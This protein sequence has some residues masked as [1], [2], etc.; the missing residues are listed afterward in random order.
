MFGEGLEINRME[1]TVTE[2]S[3]TY[4]S[5]AVNQNNNA[6]SIE[7]KCGPTDWGKIVPIPPTVNM[8][9]GSHQSPIDIRMDQVKVVKQESPKSET[10]TDKMEFW[11]SFGVIDGGCRDWTQFADDHT[12]EVNFSETA[13]RPSCKNLNVE[14]SGGKK[15]WNLKQLHFHSPSEHALESTEMAAEVHMVHKSDSGDIMVI[16]VLL[17]L[18]PTAD[19]DD[20]EPLKSTTTENDRKG[21]SDNAFLANFWE[22]AAE[23]AKY[24]GIGVEND[25]KLAMAVHDEWEVRASS[26]PINPYDLITVNPATGEAPFFSYMGSLS[27][28]P[29]TENVRWLV[30]LQPAEISKRDLYLLRKAP[31]LFSGGTLLDPITNNN[32]RPVQPLNGRIVH[33][34]PATGGG[35]TGTTPHQIKEPALL[36]S[37]G[38]DKATAL[39]FLPVLL[40]AALAL[41]L[42]IRWFLSPPPTRPKGLM[43]MVNVADA[44]RAMEQQTRTSG[45]GGGGN[46]QLQEDKVVNEEGIPTSYGTLTLT[47]EQPGAMAA[48]ANATVDFFGTMPSL[49][50][51]WTMKSVNNAVS[52][53]SSR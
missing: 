8:C 53:T 13:P 44:S 35:E 4:N 5:N 27:T 43:M 49:L 37:G 48:A 16:S 18:P 23:R 20:D 17:H 29:C 12:F 47:A 22:A 32:H 39:V 26:K 33:F 11:P 3:W 19:D 45:G 1:T 40:A 28:Y 52:T 14:F 25:D 7:N 2:Q 51:P 21:K 9:G 34:F 24:M 31:T 6:C 36:R 46:K 38:S 41:T 15:L 30:F 42:M 50:S 10:D